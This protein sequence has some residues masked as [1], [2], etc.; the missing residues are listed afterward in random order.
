M[1]YPSNDQ[2]LAFF[3]ANSYGDTYN[4]GMNNWLADWG[5]TAGTLPDKIKQAELDGF[6]FALETPG[7]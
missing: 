6:D 1:Q 5:Y 7:V 2:A 4:D 3:K